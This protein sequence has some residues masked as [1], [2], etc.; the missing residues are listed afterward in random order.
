[1]VVRP[2][3]TTTNSKRVGRTFA[4]AQC[5]ET[6]SYLREFIEWD[7]NGGVEMSRIFPVRLTGTDKGA[8]I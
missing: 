7:D 1:M 3:R 6:R 5:H 8:A 4:D 2:S